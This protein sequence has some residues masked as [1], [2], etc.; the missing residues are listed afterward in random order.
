MRI[1]S[2]LCDNKTLES[3]LAELPL[4]LNKPPVSN[5]LAPKTFSGVLMQSGEWNLVKPT[6][7][8]KIPKT[9]G[10]KEDAQGLLGVAKV[11]R[12]KLEDF[13]VGQLQEDT[14]TQELKDYMK[15]E[16]RNVTE[17]FQLNSK[18]TGT[19]AFRVRCHAGDFDRVMSP[20]TWP[21]HVSVRQWVR[22]S[23]AV[24]ALNLA[25]GDK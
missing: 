23:R 8:P 25:Y 20:S 24:G 16:E 12:V 14:T 5:T 15:K 19:A 9:Q 2:V 1:R 6:R 13:Y 17:V 21:A 4:L 10:N 22:K 18:V 11:E 7:R 3:P